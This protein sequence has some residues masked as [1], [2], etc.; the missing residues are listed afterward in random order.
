[1]S[2]SSLPPQTL[3][4]FSESELEMLAKTADAVS[5]YMGKP[6]LAEVGVSDG[7]L[8]WVAFGV[9]LDVT[10]EQDDEAIH[11]QMGGAQARLLG[12]RGGLSMGDDTQYDCLY[13]WAVEIVGT[14]GDR[15][16]KLDQ[17]G[18]AAAW[19]DTLQDVLPFALGEDAPVQDMLADDEEDDDD[20]EDDA[21]DDDFVAPSLIHP[22]SPHRH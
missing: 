8:E 10:D 1:M 12:N 19:S 20:D 2:A 21:G 16:V 22:P 17:E 5:A 3:A 13:L 7:G 6:V 11:V 14:E 15:F 9:P 18:E 4:R